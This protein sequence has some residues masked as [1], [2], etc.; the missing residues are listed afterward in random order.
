MTRKEEIRQK[1]LKIMRNKGFSGLTMR[2]LAIEMGMEAASL[3]NHVHSKD[4]LLQ[5]VCMEMAAK[6]EQAI[7]EVNDIYFNA[8]EKLA[9][10]VRAHVSILTYDMDASFV[11]LHE[12]RNLPQESKQAFLERRKHYE[13]EFR[14]IVQLGIDEGEFEDIDTKYAVITL[15]SA[16]N[17]IVEWYNPNGPLQPNEVADRLYN[18]IGKAL[19]KSIEFSR[20]SMLEP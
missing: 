19:M 15:L 1:A 3:Y 17:A 5:T 20:G 18:F 10:A 16:M 13:Y 6:L 12:W 4:E 9:M 8:S 14:K 7:L 11:F 2:G